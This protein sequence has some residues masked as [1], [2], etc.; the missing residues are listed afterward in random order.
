MWHNLASLSRRVFREASVDVKVLASAE[1]CWPGKTN[2]NFADYRGL[3]KELLC[4]NLRNLRFVA[5]RT[6]KMV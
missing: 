1:A 5:L 4:A 3:Q 6:P 2:A